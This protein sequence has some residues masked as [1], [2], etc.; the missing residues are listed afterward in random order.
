[1][2]DH[3]GDAGSRAPQGIGKTTQEK[4]TAEKREEREGGIQGRGER[5]GRQ[6][7]GGLGGGAAGERIQIGSGGRRWR[8]R[9]RGASPR[10][11]DR[12]SPWRVRG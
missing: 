9:S 1:M 10:D 7:G 11:T 6:G 12:H 5:R 4:G 2:Q 8:R 3:C